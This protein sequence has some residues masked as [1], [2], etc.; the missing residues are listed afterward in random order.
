M[1]AFFFRIVI[2]AVVVLVIM[3]IVRFMR[4]FLENRDSAPSSPWRIV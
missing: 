1:P 2:M 3:I 4:V